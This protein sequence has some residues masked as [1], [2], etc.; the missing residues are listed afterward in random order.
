MSTRFF[1]IKYKNGKEEY[2]QTD[3]ANVA[4]QVNRTFGMTVEQAEEFGVSVEMMGEG[5]V[6]PGTE[7]PEELKQEEPLSDQQKAPE[8]GTPTAEQSL[9]GHAPTITQTTNP[10][11]EGDEAPK[12]PWAQ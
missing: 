2:V 3:A 6:L 8:G 12:A 7:P 1:L 11:A 4:D 9:E 5:F 10:P